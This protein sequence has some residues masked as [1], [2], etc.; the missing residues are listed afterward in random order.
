MEGFVARGL[1]YK[2]AQRI[3]NAR[4]IDE[5]P[6]IVASARQVDFALSLDSIF[7]DCPSLSTAAQ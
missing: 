2:E 5:T 3:Y 6:A 7:A 1:P 4:E